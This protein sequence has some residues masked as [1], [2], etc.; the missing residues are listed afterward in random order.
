MSFRNGLYVGLVS[1]IAVALYLFQLWQP[2]R[3]VELHTAGLLDAIQDG[4]WPEVTDFLAP[5]YEDQWGH[6]RETV[7]AR[8]RMVARYARDLRIDTSDR[9][10]IAAGEEGEWRGRVRADADQS[11]ISAYLRQRL[12]QLESPFTARWRQQS[13][14]PWDWKLVHVSNPGLELPPGGGL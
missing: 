2:A 10:V 1:A 5:G 8:L 7:V 13:W 9:V 4:D 12:N 11:E 14:K 3:Q 6:N